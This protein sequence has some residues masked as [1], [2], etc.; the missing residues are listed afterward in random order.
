MNWYIKGVR[1][2]KW[3]T[4]IH[5]HIYT[6]IYIKGPLKVDY[7]ILNGTLKGILDGILKV[8]EMVY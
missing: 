5:I 1:S 4:Y 8:Y 7:D 2:G 6:Y 3:Y